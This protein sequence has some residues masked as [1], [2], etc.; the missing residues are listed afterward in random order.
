[1][2]LSAALLAINPFDINKSRGEQKVTVSMSNIHIEQE[3]SL[4]TIYEALNC[5]M[6]QMLELTFLGETVLVYIDEEGKLKEGEQVNGF[7]VTDDD[8]QVW[9]FAGN[10]LFVP[11]DDEQFGTEHLSVMMSEGIIQPAFIPTLK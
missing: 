1:M 7:F 11:Q 5:E 6:V 8:G 10:V 9:D 3:D 4:K 2:T